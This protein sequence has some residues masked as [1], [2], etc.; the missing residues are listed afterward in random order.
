MKERGKDKEGRRTTG[1]GGGW[2]RR[3][4]NER[5]Q[6]TFHF[7]FSV[8]RVFLY[9]EKRLKSIVLFPSEMTS[10]HLASLAKFLF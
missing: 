10:C 6:K 2:T 7:H 5:H 3:P 9:P 8:K 1:P 4:R